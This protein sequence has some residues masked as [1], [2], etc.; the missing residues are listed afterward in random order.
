MRV[1]VLL[2]REREL[3][4]LRAALD[5]AS[6]GQG[7]LLVVDGEAGIGKSA[8]L[9]YAAEEAR[10]RGFMV[11]QS[12]AGALERDVAY[13]I[14]RS[15]FDPLIHRASRDERER[16][17]AGAASLA[18]PLFG[19]GD[20]PPSQPADNAFAIRHGLYW[21]LANASE[22]LPMLLVIDDT[23]WADDATLQWLLY[24]ARSVGELSVLGLVALRPGE[25]G[26]PAELLTELRAEPAVRELRL[27]P[28]SE[29][30]CARL[31]EAE[32]GMKPHAE[33]V[34]ACHEDS[35]GNPFLLIELAR[36]LR[37][38]HDGQSAVP[39]EVVRGIG[40]VGIAR[41]LGLRLQRLGDDPTRL[42]TAVAVLEGDAELPL[43]ASMADLSVESAEAAL[44]ILVAARLLRAEKPLVFE[45]PILRT[46]VYDHLLPGQRS[47][48]HRR[49]ARLLAERGA[50]ASRVAVHLMAAG[51]A[52][53]P[54]VVEKLREQAR[55]AARGGAPAAAASILGRALAEPPPEFLRAEILFELAAV[56]R[57]LDMRQCVEFLKQA[58][59]AAHDDDLRERISVH[60][61]N[62][63]LADPA[64]WE[65]DTVLQE[66][67]ERFE[68]TAPERAARL[69]QELTAIR[70]LFH[71]E[72]G[73]TEI[74][75][76]AEGDLA[77]TPT[78]RVLLA[79]L[80][81]DRFRRTAGSAARAAEPAER[82]L[83]GPGI[84]SD[85]A[86]FFLACSVLIWTERFG[87]ARKTLD[88]A[89]ETSRARG[90]PDSWGVATAFRSLLEYE[91]GDISAALADAQSALEAVELVGFGHMV[92]SAAAR[93]VEALIERGELEA[94]DEVLRA[95]DLDGDMLVTTAGTHLLVARARLRLAQHR[96]EEAFSDGVEALTRRS[97]AGPAPP[98]GWRAAPAL[99]AL[100]GGEADRGE[101]LAN[102][103][104]RL[105]ERWE[106]PGALG[107]ALALRA[108]FVSKADSIELL[109]RAVKILGGTERRL[110][111]ARTLIDLGA[112]LRRTNRRADAR[113]PLRDGLDAAHRCGAN[114]LVA[115]ALEELRAAGARPRKVVRSGID[116]LTPSEL[117]VAHMAADGM[118]NP[119]IA[120]ALFVTRKT[121]EKHVSAVLTKLEILS[122][123]EI[124]KRL[125]FD[126]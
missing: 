29:G 55:T 22:S 117:R 81:T 98:V 74:H 4:Q 89:I 25:P 61:A 124:V 21:L 63:L 32:H 105:A 10:R 33:L 102:E 108:A 54:W 123:S 94:A 8:L 19:L 115:R 76:D 37:Y 96:L 104:L 9:A 35:G 59:D 43:A 90:T 106:L 97:I 51:P 48:A 3:V 40:S 26:A 12:R 39:S 31:I 58:L 122:R 46:S 34:R 118:S 111:H 49:A 36:A 112:A 1:S 79:A 13:G 78:D 38:L 84:S 65:A 82:A 86:P 75:V 5:A 20:A 125:S 77:E 71:A 11:L 23:H 17:L 114:A 57:A 126:S 110:D 113:G 95:R 27:G 85:T 60:L 88:R 42:A 103:E 93:L 68:T 50:P 91:Q 80:A 41:N 109:Q 56:V 116:S 44:D 73:S 83:A 87:A 24:L 64:A 99:A 66:M 2:D 18:M 47:A 52:G 45:H 72:I 53:D 67:V 28:L 92:P 30:A 100:F 119:E 6:L 15:L 62:V 70:A 121:V 16:L 7:A 107:R 14:V 101:Q 69:A 120:Q